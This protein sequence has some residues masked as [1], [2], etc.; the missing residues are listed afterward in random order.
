MKISFKL[1]F[2]L[3]KERIFKMLSEGAELLTVGKNLGITI[4][5]L[6]GEKA[7]ICINNVLN[8]FTPFKIIGHV[9]IGSDSLKLPIGKWEFSYMEYLNKEQGYIFFEQNNKLQKETV[10]KIEDLRTLGKILEKSFGM[11]YFLTNKKMDFLI[12]VNWYVIEVVG[13]AE[14]RLEKLLKY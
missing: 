11:E 12:A 3:K 5:L 13:T 7:K 2:S 8:L 10:I 9:G 14:K 6:T 1:A 4:D